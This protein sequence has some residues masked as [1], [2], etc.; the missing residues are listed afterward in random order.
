MQGMNENKKCTN[1]LSSIFIEK[2]KEIFFSV[3]RGKKMIFK[4]EM[5]SFKMG[6][7]K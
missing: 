1:S 3:L 2:K 5:N 4:I 6:E 7:K